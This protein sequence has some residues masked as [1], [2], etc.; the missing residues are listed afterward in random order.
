MVE[1]KKA[2][3]IVDPQQDFITGSLAVQGA[4]QSMDYLVDWIDKNEGELSIIAVTQDWHP[5]DHCSFEDYGGI[6]PSHCVQ[7]T[8][9]ALIYPP[10]YKKLKSLSRK[11]LE[12]RYIHK[13]DK[14]EKEEYSA[15]EERLPHYIADAELI[16]ISGI[17][18]DYCVRYTVADIRRHEFEGKLVYLPNAIPYINNNARE[19][20]C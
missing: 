2:L 19:E 9:G 13:A 11:G 7:N 6:W 15:F 17:A 3:L 16:Y 10:L 1:G 18:G 14:K 8:T 20:E 4:V 12:I 5:K